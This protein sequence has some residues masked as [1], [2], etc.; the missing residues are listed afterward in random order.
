MPVADIYAHGKISIRGW[1]SILSCLHM[2]K[3]STCHTEFPSDL[4]GE[5]AEHEHTN[6]SP[7]ERQT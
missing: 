7:R 3:D 2:D 6:D 1:V 4:V 5:V